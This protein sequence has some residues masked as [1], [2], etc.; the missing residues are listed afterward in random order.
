MAAKKKSPAGTTRR[1][2]GEEEEE[3]RSGCGVLQA[4][5]G[6]VA[7]EEDEG[8]GVD[9][10]GL[11]DAAGC[12]GETEDHFSG[13]Q[14]PEPEGVF[15]QENGLS[16]VGDDQ[17]VLHVGGRLMVPDEAAVIGVED[18]HGSSSG[19]EDAFIAEELKF[20]EA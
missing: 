10:E 6:I 11:V 7:V 15:L 4:G 14:V 2:T 8:A 16:V 20:V 13:G 18:S 17:L 3:G 19:M 5:D 1:G 9:G 12:G